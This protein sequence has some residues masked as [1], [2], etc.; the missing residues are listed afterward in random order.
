MKDILT[1]YTHYILKKLKERVRRFVTRLCGGVDGFVGNLVDVFLDPTPSD[2]VNKHG[3]STCDNTET[4]RLGGERQ[5]SIHYHFIDQRLFLV[6]RH[7]HIE[8]R[9][10]LR[11]GRSGIENPMYKGRKLVRDGDHSFAYG[12]VR[13]RVWGTKFRHG[14]AGPSP[15]M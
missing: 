3:A 5:R 8:V 6:E 13:D 12:M 2:V 11:D 14:T 1:I 4:H 9:G 15:F 7:I 10:R